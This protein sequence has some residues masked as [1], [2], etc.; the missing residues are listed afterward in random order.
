MRHE[1]VFCRQHS[2]RFWRAAAKEQSRSRSRR[3][4]AL[5]SCQ[6]TAGIGAGHPQSQPG[7]LLCPPRAAST[8]L[9]AQLPSAP[10]AAGAQPRSRSTTLQ[11]PTA[12]PSPCPWAQ[13]GPQCS[14]LPHPSPQIHSLQQDP[15]TGIFPVPLT[16]LRHTAAP[17]APSPHHREPRDEH[18]RLADAGAARSTHPAPSRGARAG[19]SLPP[20]APRQVW[21]APGS[22]K[23]LAQPL[24]TPRPQPHSA[25][26]TLAFGTSILPGVFRWPS[27]TGAC[28]ARAE[29]RSCP[30][31]CTLQRGFIGAA[32]PGPQPPAQ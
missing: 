18:P 29:E 1:Q 15:A 7:L 16:P 31:P 27:S 5:W 3:Q 23:E 2:G 24:C 10:L 13:R 20:A 4:A 26:P 9:V 19:L 30:E 8:L 17:G 14:S 6:V 12:R 32:P 21:G 22:P 25:G 28:P 11:R